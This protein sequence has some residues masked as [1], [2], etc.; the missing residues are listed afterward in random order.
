MAF[1]IG[2]IGTGNM[3]S[4]HA[5]ALAKMKGIKFAACRDIIVERAQACADKYDVPLVAQSYEQLLDAVDAVVIATPDAWHAP[6]TLQAL[7]AGKHVLS[8]KPLTVTYDEAKKVAAAAKKAKGI[9]HMVD[10]TYRRSSA[11]QAAMKLARSGALGQIRQVESS[12]LQSWAAASPAWN[13]KDDWRASYLLW[14]LCKSEGSGGVLYD[15]GCHLLDLTTACSEDLTAIRC[16]LRN[17]PKRLPNGKEVTSYDGKKLDANDAAVIELRLKSGGF[18]ISHTS[19]WATGLTNSIRLQVH[20]TEGAIRI[21]L[22]RS[23]EVLESCTGKNLSTQLWKTQTFKP[24]PTMLERFVRAVK[25]GEQ[26]QPDLLRGAKVQAYLHACE[27]SAVSHQW[28]PI[29]K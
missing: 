21:N 23:Y 17:Y 25:T 24:A 5:A 26:D 6:M 2:L 13:P 19:R 18:G 29:P 20:G 11:I 27:A 7:A 8:E 15:L 1:R 10:F 4:G 3:G 9:I 22:D 28:E 12:Y 16:E 14:K